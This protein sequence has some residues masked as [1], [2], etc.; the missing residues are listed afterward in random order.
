MAASSR[1]FSLQQAFQAHPELARVAER[2]RQSQQML[3][4]I[5]PLLQP[6]LRARVQAGPVDEDSWCLLV[7]N[8]A[9]G[10]KLKQLSPT[11]LATLQRAGYPIQRLRIKVRVG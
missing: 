11:L 10:T 2:I 9:V 8:P 3:A 1:Q 6:G 5:S 7:G 4:V